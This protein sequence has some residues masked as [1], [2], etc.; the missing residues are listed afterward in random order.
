MIYPCIPFSLL[1]HKVYPLASIIL[2]GALN[3][4]TGELNSDLFWK[5]VNFNVFWY[6]GEA[7]LPCL[8]RTQLI[9]FFQ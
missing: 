2:S 8:F 3:H 5:A 9:R 7:G 4:V 1:Y 6:L